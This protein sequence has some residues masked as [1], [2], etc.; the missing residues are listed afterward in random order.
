MKYLFSASFVVSNTV[1][2]LRHFFFQDVTNRGVL[3]VW[4]RF[5]AT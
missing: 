4:R 3:F 2:K 1:Y 5:N